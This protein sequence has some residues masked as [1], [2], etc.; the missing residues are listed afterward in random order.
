MEDR[1]LEIMIEMDE[2][3]ESRACEEK[4]QGRV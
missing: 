3:V 1:I 4:R 2:K